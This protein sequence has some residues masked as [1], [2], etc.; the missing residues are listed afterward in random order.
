MIASTKGFPLKIPIL[1]WLLG[2]VFYLSTCR[3]TTFYSNKEIN[4]LDFINVSK[5]GIQ[6]S[7]PL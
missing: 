3:E 7:V 4:E 1:K 6:I 2:V 5:T